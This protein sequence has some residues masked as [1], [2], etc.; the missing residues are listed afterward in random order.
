MGWGTI[1][2]VYI[3]SK[4]KGIVLSAQLVEMFQGFFLSD[5]E[6]NLVFK[7]VYVYICFLTGKLSNFPLPA[8]H[9]KWQPFFFFFNSAPVPCNFCLLCLKR[10]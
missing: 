1:F 8:G 10:V 3:F 4:V 6:F 9:K 5:R 7:Y 2:F